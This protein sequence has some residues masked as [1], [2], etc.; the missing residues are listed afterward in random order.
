VGQVLRARRRQRLF[1]VY[2]PSVA[3]DAL[4][5]P[6]RTYTNVQRIAGSMLTGASRK[7][8]YAEA[9][10]GTQSNELETRYL[11]DFAWTLEH[12]VEDIETKTMYRITGMEDVSTAHNTFRLDL[13]EVVQ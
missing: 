4:G 1:D 9:I 11:P 3:D 8:E 7:G 6:I 12:R 13:E 5:Q 10:Q 2:A